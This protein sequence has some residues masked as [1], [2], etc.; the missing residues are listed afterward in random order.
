M[1]DKKT[2]G[3]YCLYLVTNVLTKPNIEIIKNPSEQLSNI[4]NFEK[5][6]NCLLT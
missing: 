1:L 3:N 5:Y 6:K 2:R 4:K